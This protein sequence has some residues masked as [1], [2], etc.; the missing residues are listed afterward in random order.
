MLPLLRK[1]KDTYVIE[2]VVV[3]AD[4]GLN[5]G[6]NLYALREMGLDYVIAYRLRSN[7]AKMLPLIRDSEGW[8]VRNSSVRTDVSK[9]RVTDETRRIRVVDESIRCHTTFRH[10]FNFSWSGKTCDIRRSSKTTS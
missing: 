7:A 1:L 8:T 10:P 6:A 9:F 5:S 3:T 2:R 4:R